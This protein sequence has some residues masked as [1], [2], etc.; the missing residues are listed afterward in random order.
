MIWGP[1][2]HWKQ[3]RFVYLFAT[4]YILY[5]ESI[6]RELK[7]RPIYE[8]RLRRL[9]FEILFGQKLGMDVTEDQ[10]RGRWP[11]G[12]VLKISSLGNHKSWRSW[13]KAPSQTKNR[14]V[15]VLKTESFVTSLKVTPKPPS[16]W[17]RW[18]NMCVQTVKGAS[19]P[20]A[21]SLVPF[22][23]S[24]S[25]VVVIYCHS[26]VFM[27]QDTRLYNLLSYRV[28][29]TV[30]MLLLQD[31]TISE[32]DMR[33]GVLESSILAKPK[34][35][36]VDEAVLNSICFSTWKI[37]SCIWLLGYMP[38]HKP[39]FTKMTWY[40]ASYGM[41]EITPAHQP[42]SSSLFQPHSSTSLASMSL[43][44]RL[45]PPIPFSKTVQSIL[46]NSFVFLSFHLWKSHMF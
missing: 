18:K 4:E 17:D 11:R 39:L 45:R 16:A 12:R 34:Q 5:Y 13:E 10:K 2:T 19:Q 32:Q 28:Y 24:S 22:F 44:V 35:L 42:L 27:V 29:F 3:I 20:S 36:I 38:L 7:T 46:G 23:K 25:T 41:Y 9:L 6:K 14:E 26:K 33:I 1:H 30:Y 8:C 15:V 31:T 37:G 40:I 21:C 43:T